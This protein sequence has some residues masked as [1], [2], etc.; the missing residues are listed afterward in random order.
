MQPI[1]IEGGD[2]EWVHFKS[3]TLSS[4]VETALQIV[5]GKVKGQSYEV[6][7]DRLMTI[8]MESDFPIRKRKRLLGKLRLRSNRSREWIPLITAHSQLFAVTSYRRRLIIE[9]LIVELEL[10]D[11]EWIHLILEQQRGGKSMLK[12]LVEDRKVTRLY[13]HYRVFNSLSV[14][15]SALLK[16]IWLSFTQKTAMSGKKGYDDSDE[17][18]YEETQYEADGESITAKTPTVA[19]T[20]REITVKNHRLFGD[21]AVIL[22]RFNNAAREK[23]KDEIED[24]VHNEFVDRLKYDQYSNGCVFVDNIPSKMYSF[25]E[26]QRVR[27]DKEGLNGEITR[28]LDDHIFVKSD[29]NSRM[30]SYRW[31]PRSESSKHI[32][33]RFKHDYDLNN[34]KFG[35]GYFEK[36]ISTFAT[37][38]GVSQN[39]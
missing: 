9:R 19:N 4:N 12:W 35:I 14:R 31:I 11:L 16:S 1:N 22:H 17:S 6:L 7:V 3:I 34:I 30:I 33:L 15:S 26:G 29:S 28:V 39:G 38:F 2:Y 25:A 10:W 8:L 18:C 36:G 5:P 23:V 20:V 13:D 27:L 37:M 24:V 21:R 32:K